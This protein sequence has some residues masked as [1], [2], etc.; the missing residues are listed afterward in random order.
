MITEFLTDLGAM[1]LATYNGEVVG[2]SFGHPSEKAARKSLEQFQRR[3]VSTV[4]DQALREASNENLF[5]HQ[6]VCDQLEQFAAGEPIDFVDVPVRTAGM[7]GFQK[8]VV[9]ACRSIPWGETF[10]YGQLAAEVGHSGAAR[11]VGTVMSKNRV[12]L[13]V[14]C[15]R[16]LAS[17]GSLGGYSAPQGL[18]MKRRLLALEKMAVMSI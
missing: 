5:F 1:S 14:P 9:A 18:A 16:V 10:T 2:L 4:F 17:G 8:Q 6:Q 15:H 13:I 3:S 11:A 7:T 12:P